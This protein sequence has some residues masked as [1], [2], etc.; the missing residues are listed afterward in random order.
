[1]V[2]TKPHGLN[3]DGCNIGDGA[4]QG[5]KNCRLLRFLSVYNTRISDAGVEII[6]RECE[7]LR[8]LHLGSCPVTDR[9]LMYLSSKANMDTIGVW[10]TRSLQR[11]WHSLSAPCRTV[12]FLWNHPN[13]SHEQTQRNLFVRSAAFRWQSGAGRRPCKTGLRR[14]RGPG[15]AYLNSRRFQP[16]ER[17]RAANSAQPQRG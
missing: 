12:G 16:A 4:L 8:A 3:L 9:S 6:A 13:G 14:P 1:M 7:Q 5:I 10:R 17:R 11:V 2:L 15:G